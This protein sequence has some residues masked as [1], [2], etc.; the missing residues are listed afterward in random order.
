MVLVPCDFQNDGGPA[1]VRT[2]ADPYGAPGISAEEQTLVTNDALLFLR[3]LFFYAIAEDVRSPK[4]LETGLIWN[5]LKTLHA[6]EVPEK[7]E[8]SNS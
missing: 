1:I 2:E 6:I 5:S 7:W 3:M 4:A 8:K